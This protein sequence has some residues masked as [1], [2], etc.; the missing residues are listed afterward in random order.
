MTG[1]RQGHFCK[2]CQR[3]RANEKFDGRSHALHICKDYQRALKAARR[4][5]NRERRQ[6]ESTPASG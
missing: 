1:K 2:I 4:Q 6:N 3:Y 5:K